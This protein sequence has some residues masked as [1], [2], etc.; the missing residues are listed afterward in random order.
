M[1]FDRARF[2]PLLTDRLVLRRFRGEDADAFA[3]YR[4]D[5]AVARF[6][7]WEAPYPH[8]AARAFVSEMAEA[9][10]GVP[11]EWFQF[12]VA[13]VSAPHELIGDVALHVHLDDPTTAE[14][15]FTLAAAAQGDGYATEAATAIMGWA[16]EHLRQVERM[17]AIT[18]VR[19][20]GSIGVLERLGMTKL[21]EEPTT[22]KDE[23]CVEA[24]YERRRG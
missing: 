20:V 8:E 22:F 1:L 2:E 11:G 5:P 3:R 15:G 24:T 10:P 13:P 17:I 9:E 4:S 18:D 19:N 23:P 7:S 12:A 14:L 6:Q 16:F 21:W